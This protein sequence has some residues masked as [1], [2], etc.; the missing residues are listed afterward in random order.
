MEQ[1][2]SYFEMQDGSLWS[3]I[4]NTTYQMGRGTEEYDSI[5]N[6]IEELL[7]KHPNLRKVL[8]D[9]TPMELSKSDAE[10]LEKIQVLY[11]NK[12][13]I[14]MRNAFFL[15]GNNLYYYFKQLRLLDDEKQQ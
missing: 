5:L 15:G 12:R 2:E 13:D 10:A 9:N 8:E 4:E 6:D 3:Y 1:L 11:L 14:D 7:K